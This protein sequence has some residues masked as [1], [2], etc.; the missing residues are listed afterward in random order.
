MKTLD[1]DSLR[2]RWAEQ[3]RQLDQS[4]EMDVAAVRAALTRRTVSAFRRHAAW[5]LVGL[6]CA[7]GILALLLVFVAAHWGQWSWML[8]GLSLVP[9]ALS[10]AVVDALEWQGLRRIDFDMPVSALKDRLDRL[11]SL[12]MRQVRAFF[13]CSLLLWLPM[14]MVAF[15]GLFGAD[16]LRAL[17]PSVLWVNV[18]LG[19]VFIPLSLGVTAWVSRRFAGT[20]GLRRYRDDVAGDSWARARAE[21]ETRDEFDYLAQDDAA[22]ALRSHDVPAELRPDLARLRRRLLLGILTCAAGMVA[23]GLFNAVQGG[24]AQFLVPGVLLNLAVA[25]Q[26]AAGIQLRLSLSLKAGG[27][28]ALRER[29]AAALALRRRFAVAGVVALPL[30]LTALA[31]VLARVLFALDLSATVGG[32]GT[33][34]VLGLAMAGVGLAWRAARR[35]GDAFAPRLAEAMSLGGLA[36]SRA[37]QSRLAP[38]DRSGT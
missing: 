13:A 27:L 26:M 14:V 6:G 28:P 17:H 4:L 20:A 12:R 7:L 38:T 21:L 8:L 30:V 18:A 25:A 35:Q 36:S 24:R 9:L 32:G 29:F 10:E 1:L 5:L 3:G 23:I 2:G 33:A 15:K 16:L 22:N 31:Q 37:L 34:L 11:Q 19:L